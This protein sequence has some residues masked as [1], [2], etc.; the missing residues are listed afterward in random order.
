MG[1]TAVNQNS[2]PVGT[3]GR[4]GCLPVTPDDSACV[5]RK[6]ANDF[7]ELVKY[8]QE[9]YKL[10]YR[11]AYERAAEP[12]P[13]DRMMNVSEDQVLSGELRSLA[14][15]YPEQ[16]KQRWEQIKKAAC[17]ELQTGWHAAR[18]LDDSSATCW[19]RAKFLAIRTE[20]RQAWRPRNAQEAHL[21]DRARPVNG[22]LAMYGSL[23]AFFLGGEPS[24]R[25]A[26]RNGRS[27]GMTC[28]RSGDNPSSPSP[29]SAIK[30]T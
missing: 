1:E 8:Y 14:D 23:V 12:F 22:R 17:A 24:C 27:N 18:L 13:P 16:A 7:G 25:V 26:I 11:E 10:C 30:D 19:S 3:I 29:H 20:L 28:S 15:E 21:I 9:Q 4:N 5:A 2:E 6:L